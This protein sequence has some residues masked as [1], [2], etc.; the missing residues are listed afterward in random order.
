MLKQFAPCIFV[1]LIFITGSTPA[2]SVDFSCND[3]QQGTCLEQGDQVCASTSRCVASNSLCFDPAS[4]KGGEFICKSNL[5]DYAEKCNKI[6]DDYKDLLNRYNELAAQY[7]ALAESKKKL[8]NCV[9]YASSL[10]KAKSCGF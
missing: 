2:Y 6:A 7:N 10:D 3:G 5:D 4:C 8:K 1:S 9:G